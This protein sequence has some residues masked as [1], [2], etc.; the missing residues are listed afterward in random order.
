MLRSFFVILFFLF[1]VN[2]LSQEKL[3]FNTKEDTSDIF[4]GMLV[5]KNKQ[6]FFKKCSITDEEILIVNKKGVQSTDIQSTL[7]EIRKKGSKIQL[8]T[9]AIIKQNKG[10]YLIHIVEIKNIIVNKSCLLLDSLD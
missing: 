8:E 4:F 3:I 2:L 5:K 10:K 6:F 1:S 9:I 7:E